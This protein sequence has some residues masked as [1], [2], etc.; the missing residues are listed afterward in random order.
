MKKLLVIALVA[1]TTTAFAGKSMIRMSGFDS[2]DRVNSFD[3]SMSS[4][5]AD[6]KTN[7]THININYAYE[8]ASQIQVGIGYQSLTGEL[9][10]A[11]IGANTITVSGYYNFL[12]KI[13]DSNYVALHYAMTSYAEATS[14]VFGFNGDKDDSATTIT[15]EYGKRWHV[16]SGWGFDLTYAPSVQYA[17]NTFTDDSA[18]DSLATN[19]LSWNFGK[20]DILF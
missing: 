3:L 19:T 17:M 11:D 13:Q 9:G 2:G 15:L 7:W 12:K 14:G 1:M 20:F 5:D 8:V 10:G 18:D 6:S 16:G 4:N